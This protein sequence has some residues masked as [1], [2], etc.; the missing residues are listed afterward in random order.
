MNVSIVPLDRPLNEA[1]LALWRGY[2]EFYQV[3]DID[4]ERNRAHVEQIAGNAS[5]GHIHLAVV[6]GAPVG[7]STLYYTFTSTRSCKVA[8]LNDLF[9]LPERRRLGVGRALIDHALGF[10]RAAGIR[11]VRWSTAASNAEAQKLYA[12]Y[13]APTLWKMYSVDVSERPSP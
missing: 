8:L 12:A 5:L 13:G 1:L 7:F 9:V 6:D 3:G 11:Y 2:Q 4:E 10:A